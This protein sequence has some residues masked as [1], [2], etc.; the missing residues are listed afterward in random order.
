LHGLWLILACYENSEILVCVALVSAPFDQKF[1]FSKDGLKE[2][3]HFNSR[4]VGV[5]HAAQL[6]KKRAEFYFGLL[7][8]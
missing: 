7:Q 4:L 2:I 5:D 6:R 3:F 8:D 1:F